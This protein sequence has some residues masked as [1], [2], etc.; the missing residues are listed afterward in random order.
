MSRSSPVEARK[1]L[2]TRAL[3]PGSGAPSDSKYRT[4]RAPKLRRP[5]HRVAFPAF[6]HELAAQRSPNGRR[7]GWHNVK[8]WAARVAQ[9][10][11]L[12]IARTARLA[13]LRSLE[14]ATD[15]SS[16]YDGGWLVG[17]IRTVI[18]EHVRQNGVEDTAGR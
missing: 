15:R 16:L 14:E 13:A 2:A 12:A 7:Q 9:C 18:A 1:A 4:R 11:S 10:A 8:L 3:S 17:L 6:R 5:S